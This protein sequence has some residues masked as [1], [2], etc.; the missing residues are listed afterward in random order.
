MMDVKTGDVMLIATL[1]RIQT[2]VPAKPRERER[3]G[4]PSSTFAGQHIQ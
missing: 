3:F 2:R 1:S 4:V